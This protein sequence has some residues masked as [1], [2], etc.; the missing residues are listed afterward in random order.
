[1]ELHYVG[2]YVVAVPALIV[3]GVVGA[4]ATA[5]RRAPRGWDARVTVPLVLAA[6]AAHLSLIPAVE[7][8]RQVLFG[9]YF[10]AMAGVV[11]FALLGFGIW[12]LGAI[13]FPVG[14][15]AG[16]F[17]FGFVV[18]QVDYVGLAVKLVELAAVAS[19]LVPLMRRTST[20]DAPKTL[21]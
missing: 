19:A 6:G 5:F 20:P 2:A 15:I 16:Y 21:A 10:L 8:Q 17:Y 18:H 13:V 12:R 11:A 14:S 4:A 9:L 7:L 3:G 1:M